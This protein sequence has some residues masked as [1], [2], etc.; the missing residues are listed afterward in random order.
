MKT[1]GNGLRDAR[2]WPPLR[3]GRLEQEASEQ[4]DSEAD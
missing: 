1:T 4:E 3:R 2:R